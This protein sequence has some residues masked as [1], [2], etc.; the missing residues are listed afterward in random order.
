MISVI[1]FKIKTKGNY[2]KNDAIRNDAIKDDTIKNDKEEITYSLGMSS[3]VDKNDKIFITDSVKLAKKLSYDNDDYKNALTSYD[4]FKEFVKESIEKNGKTPIE[5]K[6]TIKSNINFNINFIKNVLFPKKSTFKIDKTEELK[7]L[8]E[9]IKI[10]GEEIKKEGELGKIE[11]LKKR[12]KNLKERAELEKEGN[13]YIINGISYIDGNYEKDPYPN[14]IDPNVID[15]NAIDG[16]Y[17]AHI[18]LTL[19]P[20][21]L[22]AG[23]QFRIKTTKFKEA[24]KNEKYDSMP[25]PGFI[26]ITPSVKLTM[27]DL[28]YSYVNGDYKKLLTSYSDFSALVD[29]IATKQDI[30]DKRDPEYETKKKE[31]LNNNIKLIKNIFFPDKSKYSYRNQKFVIVKSKYLDNDYDEKSYAEYKITNNYKALPT[32]YQALANNVKIVF[33]STLE[34]TFLDIP[35]GAEEPSQA[36]FKRLSCGEKAKELENQFMYYFDVSLNLFEKPKQ[37]MVFKSELDKAKELE[38]KKKKEE[39]EKRKEEKRKE[40][41]IR[42]NLE[43]KERFL[44]LKKR[45]DERKKKEEEELKIKQQSELKVGGK[46]KSKKVGLYKFIK[47][48]ITRKR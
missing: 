12:E 21:P 13:R 26:F 24:E 22:I 23:L 30:L 34:F 3:P 33:I 10:N 32:R 41:I 15:P 4:K 11:E 43:E 31:V 40:D 8:E 19:K 29:Y 28:H 39:E 44:Y 20:L 25:D 47:K 1:T 37:T 17:I 27:N 9:A 18:E 38:I 16:N 42:K 46:K 45:D 36:D 6:E 5:D 35:L 48:N 7:R 14:K 2:I